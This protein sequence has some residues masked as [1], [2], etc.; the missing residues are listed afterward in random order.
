MTTSTGLIALVEVSYTVHNVRT[1]RQGHITDRYSK[2][3]E[4]LG[5]DFY[6]W[7]SGQRQELASSPFSNASKLPPGGTSPMAL[8]SSQPGPE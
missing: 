2:A 6:S 4:Q 1:T 5:S 3:I 8:R 7:E